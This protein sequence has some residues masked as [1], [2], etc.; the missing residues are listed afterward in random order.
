MNIKDGDFIVSRDRWNLKAV[1][2]IKIT[3]QLVFYRDTAWGDRER[4]VR[5]SD[6]IFSGD[7]AVADR[8]VERLRSS[9]ARYDEEQRASITRRVQRDE[10]LLEAAFDEQFAAVGETKD[11]AR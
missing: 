2:V 7:K 5:I 8:L 10:K 11:G 4:R 9:E 3:P 6:V 1:Q